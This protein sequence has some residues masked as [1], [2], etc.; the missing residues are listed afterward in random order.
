LAQHYADLW[1]HEVKLYRV[2]FVYV[3]SDP[4]EPA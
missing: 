3:G 2:P 4:L 1:Q